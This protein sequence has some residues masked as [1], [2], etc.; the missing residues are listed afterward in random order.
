MLRQ[1][2]L[3][4]FRNTCL[5]SKH[6]H[7]I[8]TLHDAHCKR[9]KTIDQ[10]SL[11]VFTGNRHIFRRTGRFRNQEFL[12]SRVPGKEVPGRVEVPGDLVRHR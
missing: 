9:T 1:L 2:S 5:R 6:S 7:K 4:L 12:Q 11:F 3:V 8:L 10:Q